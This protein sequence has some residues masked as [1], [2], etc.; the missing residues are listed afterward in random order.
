MQGSQGCPQRKDVK[1]QRFAKDCESPKNPCGPLR[2]CVVVLR[3]AQLQEN[4]SGIGSASIS[5]IGRLPG[6]GIIV[7]SRSMPIAR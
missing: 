5:R 7:V 6:P 1:V 3:T 2:L 4:S